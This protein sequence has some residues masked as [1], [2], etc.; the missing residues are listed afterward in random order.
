[1]PLRPAAA[2]KAIPQ[3]ARAFVLAAAVSIAAVTASDTPGNAA[4]ETWLPVTDVSLRIARG[5]ALDFSF[6]ATESVAGEKGNLIATPTGTLAFPGKPAVPARF[7]CA[8]LAWSPASGS[9]PDHVTADIY[10]GQLRLHGYNLARLH[11]T[12]AILMTDRVADFDLDP[13]Q[14]DNF[15]YLLAALKRNGIRWMIDAATSE[16]G[17]YG[18]VRPHRWDAHYAHKIDVHVSEDARRHWLRLASAFLGTTN[19][20]TGTRPL[21]DPALAVIT[22]F[23]EDGLEYASLADEQRTHRVYPD[24]LREPFNA[25]LL[26]TYKNTGNLAAAWSGELGKGE[27]LEWRTVDLPKRR[28]ARGARTRDLQRFFLAREEETFL[29]MATALRHL[30]FKGFLTAYNNWPTTESHLARRQLPLVSVDSYHDIVLSLDTNV[31]I[32]QSSSLDDDLKYVRAMMATRWLGRP[33][34]VSEYDH[35]FWNSFRHE[36]GLA[37]P[38]YAALQGWDGLCRHGSGP[39]DLA[40]GS[41]LPH[42]Q[43]LLPYNLGMDPIARASETLSALLFRRGDVA[44]SPATLPVPMSSDRDFLGDGLDELPADLTRLG[45]LTGFG[46]DDSPGKKPDATTPPSAAA[47]S[48]PRWVTKAIAT[49]SGASQ[50]KFGERLDALVAAGRLDAETVGLAKRRIYRSD[51]GQIRADAPTRRIE[52]VT[53]LTEAVSFAG[54]SAPL[55]LGRMTLLSATGPALVAVSAL[56]GAPIAESRKLLL[57]LS[58]DAINSGM[59][60]KDAARRTVTDYGHLP[61]L[62]RRAAT[63]ISLRVAPLSSAAPERIRLTALRLDGTPE[64]AIPVN[65]TAET[66]DFTLDIASSRHGPTTF[67]LLER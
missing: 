54:V 60:F 5:S 34:I 58:T 66:M 40:Y 10:A 37:V 27:S 56:D 11:F 35:L 65:R 17:A 15:R 41:G 8:S 30:G 63:K 2:R 42:K 33:F 55:H 29:W 36:A 39:I 67:F 24:Q 4:G 22:T 44:R 59:T 26:A 31:T 13:V 23:N 20:Y 12:D 48:L 9:Y 3:F 53:P 38:A 52:V 49:V 32:E 57:I 43:K 18:N 28:N 45:L 1:M 21:D 62:I 16:N 46:L 50:A 51:T 14:L 25:W 6:L 64:D 61:V 7:H 19:P 47:S